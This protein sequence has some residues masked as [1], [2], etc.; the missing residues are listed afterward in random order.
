[1]QLAACQVLLAHKEKNS[2][3]KY[4]AQIRGEEKAKD[5]AAKDQI[6]KE[7]IDKATSCLSMAASAMNHQNYALRGGTFPPPTP[8]QS[9]MAVTNRQAA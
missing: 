2:L 6:R 3:I 9:H 1:M 7:K 5:L 8:A 4:T